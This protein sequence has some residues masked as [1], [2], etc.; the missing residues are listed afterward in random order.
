MDVDT[1]VDAGTRLDGETWEVLDLDA[2]I[3][4]DAVMQA[5]KVSKVHD[6]GLQR[7]CL[8]MLDDAG[9]KDMVDQRCLT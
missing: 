2:H 6:Q 1:G 9:P 4:L 5:L 3:V 8:R 7:R